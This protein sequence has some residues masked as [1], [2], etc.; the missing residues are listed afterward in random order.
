MAN[1]FRKPAKRTRRT[2]VRDLIPTNE[3]LLI[4]SD[5]LVHLTSDRL[6]MVAVGAKAYGLSCLPQ[7]W[8]L[9]HF[10]VNGSVIG[11]NHLQ[12]WINLAIQKSGLKGRVIVR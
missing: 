12:D 5:G 11:D 1:Q 9:P 10:V 4:A 2:S 3:V 8:V 6:E 7:A